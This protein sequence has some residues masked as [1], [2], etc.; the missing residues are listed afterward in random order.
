MSLGSGRSV[1]GK[2]GDSAVAVQVSGSSSWGDGGSNRSQCGRTLFSKEE[3]SEL[4]GCEGMVELI[5]WFDGMRERKGYSC[6]A[7]LKPTPIVET[8][9]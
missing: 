2:G 5:D 4:M 1:Y 7:W 9:D 6:L 3:R 8:R